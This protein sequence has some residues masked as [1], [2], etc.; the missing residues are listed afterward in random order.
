MKLANANKI[1]ET[2]IRKI[3]EFYGG[4]ENDCG[5]ITS[6]SFNIPIVAEDGEEGWLEITAKITKDSGDDGYLKRQAYLLNLAEKAEKK[7]QAEEK[8]AK[9]IASD[10][11][12]RAE[13]KRKAGQT[14]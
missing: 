10:E 2:E 1:R 12:R 14:A 7:K 11:K 5:M 13:L 4:E 8:K 6:N 9:K 3:F